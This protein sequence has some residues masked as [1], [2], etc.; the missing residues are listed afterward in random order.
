MSFCRFF[1]VG[2]EV[3]PSRLAESA[4]MNFAKKGAG[5]NS[6]GQRSGTTPAE[7]DPLKEV[8]AQ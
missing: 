2:G 4:F 6:S 7:G 1:G 5:A 3:H 8:S